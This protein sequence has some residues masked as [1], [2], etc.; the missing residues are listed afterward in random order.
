LTKFYP[1]DIVF[2]MATRET[3]PHDG[4]TTGVTAYGEKTAEK[5]ARNFR[6]IALW[7]LGNPR[8]I[9]IV[10]SST[11]S[12][13]AID[14]EKAHLRIT[15]ETQIYPATADLPAM[16][17][18]AMDDLS[19]SLSLGIVRSPTRLPQ[20]PAIPEK[21]EL[22]DLAKLS[23]DDLAERRKNEQTVLKQGIKYLME[24]SRLL[25]MPGAEVLE[26]TKGSENNPPLENLHVSPTEIVVTIGLG[27][28]N[29]R[30]VRAHIEMDGSVDLC[31]TDIVDGNSTEIGGI[32]ALANAKSAVEN[33]LPGFFIAKEPTASGL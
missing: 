30:T 14:G 28:F 33:F 23:P 25:E 24:V 21:I 3:I 5:K 31:V 9:K 16:I 17:R 8:E 19:K 29:T 27:Q 1:N 15:P 11:D 6:T 18:P 32:E 13:G 12:N 10:W 22:A 20:F 7:I 4:T 26:I 2:R